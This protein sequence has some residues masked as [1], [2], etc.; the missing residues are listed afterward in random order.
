MA[1]LRQTLLSLVNRDE[2]IY[3]CRKNNKTLVE[4]TVDEWEIVFDDQ[5]RIIDVRMS[6]DVPQ[7]G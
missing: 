6:L 2:V 3:W 7:A 5:G 4:S 1:D